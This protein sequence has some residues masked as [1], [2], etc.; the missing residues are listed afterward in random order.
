MEKAAYLS[1]GD[2]ILHGFTTDTNASWLARALFP[3]GWEFAEGRVIADDITVIQE[4]LGSLHSYPL[5]IITGGLGPTDDDVT[6]EGVASYLNKGLHFQEDLWQE[7]SKRFTSTS[8][9]IPPSNRKQAFLIDGAIALYNKNGTAPGQLIREDGKTIVL[10]PG[11]PAENRPMFL[12]GVLPLLDEKGRSLMRSIISVVGG[13]ES[14]VAGKMESLSLEGIRAG[15]YYNKNGWVEIHLQNRSLSYEKFIK[16]SES[17]REL[18]SRDPL[19]FLFSG[20]DLFQSLFEELK[21]R[22]K[23]AAFAES[24]TGGLAGDRLA[25]IP[26]A[27]EV[28]LGSIV[29]YDNGVKQNILGVD[30]ETLKTCGAVSQETALEMVR[31]ICEKTGAHCGISFTGIA[32]PSGGSIE[33]PLGLVYIGYSVDGKCSVEKHLLRGSRERIRFQSVSRGYAGLLQRLG[34]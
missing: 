24:L 21:K 34:L 31:G 12:E 10:L 29:A 5:I 27:S 15:Y 14:Y 16:K 11:P 6:R 33:K 23:K 17:L 2:E 19:L 3:S 25:A 26:G 4:A 8:R 9:A 1:I 32:G 20:R 22:G 30:P 28:F 18:L 7:I 13:G